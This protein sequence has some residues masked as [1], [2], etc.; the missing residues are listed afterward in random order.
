MFPDAP[1]L[2][3]TST[4]CPSDFESLSATVRARM[5]VEPPGA[6]GTMIFTGRSGQ[7]ACAAGAHSASAV[8]ITVTTRMSDMSDSLRLGSWIRKAGSGTA[9]ARR[10]R[11]PPGE[12]SPV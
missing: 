11:G 3:S 1:G 12:K 7:A 10:L 9:L 5:S 8:M 2:F 4:G 6:H